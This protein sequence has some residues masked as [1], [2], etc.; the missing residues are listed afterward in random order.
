W[1]WTGVALGLAVAIKD[2]AYAI[3]PVLGLACWF[4]GPA[5]R[6]RRM[7]TWT[8]AAVL[9]YAVAAGALTAP[10]VWW[11]HVSYLLSGGVAGVDRIDHG[12]LGDW[13][14]LA[15]HAAV[16]SASAIGWTGLL[17]GVAG[18]WRLRSRSPATARLLAGSAGA[19]V[20]LFVLPA[21]FVFVRFLLLPL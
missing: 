17:L 3:A 7:A 1:A 16:L 8:A 9:T 20:L 14:L 12:R 21:G 10:T 6:A 11:Q 2:P 13:W 5:G 18:L 19:T 15:R 4:A